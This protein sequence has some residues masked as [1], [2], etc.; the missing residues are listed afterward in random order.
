[1]SHTALTCDLVCDQAQT[2]PDFLTVQVYLTKQVDAATINNI[3]IHGESP[4]SRSR[5]FCGLSLLESS[6][7]SK[8]LSTL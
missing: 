6:Q 8:P 1:M 2:D 4:S 3:A 5:E 7:L